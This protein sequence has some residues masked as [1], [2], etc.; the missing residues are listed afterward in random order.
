[1]I[2][3]CDFCNGEYKT[4][5]NWYKRNKHHTCSRECS[6]NLKKK[7]SIK[8][9]KYCNIDFYSKSH[10]NKKKYCSIICSSKAQDKKEIL[11]CKIC[12][13]EYKVSKC[14]VGISKFCSKKCLSKHTGYLASLRIGSL[15]KNYKGFDD[16]KRKNKSKLKSWANVIKNRD[17]S[18]KKCNSIVNL[19]S[20]HIKSYSKYPELRFDLENGILLCNIC[21]AKE[22]E[23]DIRQV[24]NLILKRYD[25]KELDRGCSKIH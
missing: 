13:K 19:Q 21:H 14:R 10:Q 5:L 2:I 18:C 22:H 11:N 15:N 24:K 3:I 7:L 6:D 17:K 1:M 23:N 12:N 4:F 9:C 25:K 8:K 16:T 20:H